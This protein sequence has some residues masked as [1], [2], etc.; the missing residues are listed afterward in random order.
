MATHRTR[1]QR[2]MG[3]VLMRHER[4]RDIG[5]RHAAILEAIGPC[6]GGRAVARAG[7]PI[8]QALGFMVARLRAHAQGAAGWKPAPAVSA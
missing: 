5:D 3:E 1:T 8:T 6:T 4:R 7:K 2:A